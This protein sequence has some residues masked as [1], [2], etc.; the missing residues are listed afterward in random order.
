MAFQ[1]NEQGQYSLD[2]KEGMSLRLEKRAESISTLNLT[3]VSACLQMLS[4][5][6]E[7]QFVLVDNLCNYKNKEILLE[8]RKRNI[9]KLDDL[10]KDHRHDDA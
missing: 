1:R 4:A 9:T 5:T 8:Y 2:R 3:C 7:I 10:N 6:K